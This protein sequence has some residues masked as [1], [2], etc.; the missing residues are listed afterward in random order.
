V[1][2]S[3]DIRGFSFGFEAVF[4]EKRGAERFVDPNV[5]AVATY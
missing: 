1:W 4:L 3:N 2:K 5:L